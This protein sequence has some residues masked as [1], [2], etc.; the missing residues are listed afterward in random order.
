MVYLFAETEEDRAE[1]RR[2]LYKSVKGNYESLTCVT[3]DHLEYPKLQAKL[4]LEP[5]VFPA[6]AVHQL[7]TNRIYPYPRN[8]PVDSRSL[9][10]WGLDVWQGRIKPRSPD[11]ATTGPSVA[12]P[13]KVA[14]RKVSVA[15]IPGVNIRVAGRDEL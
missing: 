5:G 14:T 11:G 8:L 6:G 4:G 9:Q 12:E 1:L 13:R 2:S 10:K 3:V 7:S 15:N